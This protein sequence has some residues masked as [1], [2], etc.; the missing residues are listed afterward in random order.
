M[1]DLQRQQGAGGRVP[2]RGVADAIERS[3]YADVLTSGVVLTGGAAM[4]PGMTE[5]AAHVMR[6]QVRLGE[7]Q[8]VVGL[9]DEIDDP[10]WST[11]VGLARGIKSNDL[12]SGMPS[13]IG[14]RVMPQWLWRKWREYF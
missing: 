9:S 14:A 13:G 5:V 2:A 8:G 3:G 12:R 7:P 10:S 4:M 11:A 1:A 6:Q